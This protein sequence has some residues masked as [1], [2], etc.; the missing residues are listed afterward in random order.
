MASVTENYSNFKVSAVVRFL[1]L[2]GLSQSEIHCSL[3]SIYG[4]HIFSQ[5]EVSV[6]YNKLKVGQVALDDD[7]EKHRGRLGTSHSEEEL[8]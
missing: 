1:L 5:K 4:K 8:L 6:S 7:P 3:V 2:E